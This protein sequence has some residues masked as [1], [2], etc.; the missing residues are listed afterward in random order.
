MN[1]ENLN[2]NPEVNPVNVNPTPVDNQGGFVEA[3]APATD[4]VQ[5]EAPVQEVQPV[6]PALVQPNPMEN[7][8]A[9]TTPVVNSV[10]VTPVSEVPVNNTQSTMVAP[11]EVPVMQPAAANHVFS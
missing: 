6:Q 4:S 2:N 8:D 3:S 11:T 9:G 1:E 5:A 10:P 7:V